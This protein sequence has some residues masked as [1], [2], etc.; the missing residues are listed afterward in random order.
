MEK[1]QASYLYYYWITLWGWAVNLGVAKVPEDQKLR[2]KAS[3]RA[4][5]TY[6]MHGHVYSV[7]YLAF[8]AW[9]LLALNLICGLLAP[10]N[11]L[12]NAK[13]YYRFGRIFQS[14]SFVIAIAFIDSAIGVQSG[15]ELLFFPAIASVFINFNYEEKRD[16]NIALGLT[17]LVAVGSRL[18]TSYYQPWVTIPNPWMP[19]VSAMVWLGSI[20]IFV[21]QISTLFKSYERSKKEV[22]RSHAHT[23]AVMESVDDGFYVVDSDW[24]ILYYNPTAASFLESFGVKDATGMNFW[25]LIPAV[26]EQVYV[27]EI[28]EAMKTQSRYRREFFD[29]ASQLWSEIIA[30]PTGDGMS[31]TFRGIQDR[32]LSEIA[33]RDSEQLQRAIFE[34]AAT[35]LNILS[36][37]GVF[38]R[39]NGE[40][41]RLLGYTEQELVGMTVAQLTFEGDLEKS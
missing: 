28:K 16:L 37:E 14:V 11:L 29:T 17:A 8:G 5:L 31:V 24:T 22:I 3:N 6:W 18:L 12:L 27:P 26:N 19:Y 7:V 2:V 1:L 38:L 23:K 4:V 21:L 41:C 39:V 13:G 33:L 15:I 30:Y 32:K 40:M 36:P 10:V 25:H 20:L 9:N 35:G 34:E